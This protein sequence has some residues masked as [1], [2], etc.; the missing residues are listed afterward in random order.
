MAKDSKSLA[1][2]RAFR[3]SFLHRLGVKNMPDSI[4]KN[5]RSDRAMDVFVDWKGRDYNTVGK[6]RRRGAIAHPMLDRVFDASGKCCRGKDGA[7]SRFP[8]NIGRILLNFYCPV[9]GIVFDPF[10]GHNSRM[11]L[12][13]K[14]GRD[15]IGMDISD[16]FMCANEQIRQ[17][18]LNDNCKMLIKRENSIQLIHGDSRYVPLSSEIADFTITSPPYWDLEWY[19]DENEQLGRVGTYRGFLS[20]LYK[21][22]QENYRVLSPGSF[23]I[24]CVND[25]RKN[26]VFYPYHLDVA[27]LG[28]R[29]GFTIDNFYI[30]DLGHPVVS[31]FA[32]TIIQS[33]ALAK[34]HE[35][36]IVY[37]KQGANVKVEDHFNKM[38]QYGP[39]LE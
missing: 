15:Y 13:Y 20:G 12:V 16:M 21:C 14:S 36:A 5:D 35:Y 22:L 32:K 24:W 25:F 34:R 26:G 7:L 17:K 9:D 1:R 23:C 27:I 37:R 28:S 11:E 6:K 10:A 30:L 18:L 3:Q 2:S 8:Q 29:A 39:D 31:S 33:R 4:L 38:K 19:G